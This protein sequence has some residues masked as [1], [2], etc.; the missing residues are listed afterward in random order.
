MPTSEKDLQRILRQIDARATELANLQLMKPEYEAFCIYGAKQLLESLNLMINEAN[1]E[2]G[3]TKKEWMDKLH[4][5]ESTSARLD[6]KPEQS[7]D[8][9]FQRFEDSIFQLFDY[10]KQEL[11]VI[12]EHFAKV[13]TRYFYKFHPPNSSHPIPPENPYE[14]IKFFYNENM[15]GAIQEFTW[16]INWKGLNSYPDEKYDIGIS[17]SFKFEEFLYK[18]MFHAIKDPLLAKTYSNKVMPA[19]LSRVAGPISQSV[20]ER[21]LTQ[22]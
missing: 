1:D 2:S 10:C 18:V 11:E 15:L 4:L 20:A 22:S 13:E 12:N 21:I 14:A 19:D 7:N 17:V 9:V 3:E 8:I 5:F 16:I 6:D